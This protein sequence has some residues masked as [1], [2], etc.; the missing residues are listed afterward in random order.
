MI[1]FDEG[2]YSVTTPSGKATLLAKEY[3]LLRFLYRH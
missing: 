1:D 3:A 2:T